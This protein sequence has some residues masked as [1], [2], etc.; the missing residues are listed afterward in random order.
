[1]AEILPHI[2]KQERTVLV[3]NKKQQSILWGKAF[4]QLQTMAAESGLFYQDK[5]LAPDFFGRSSI[6]YEIESE[7]TLHQV[8]AKISTS[9]REFY[10]DECSWVCPGPPMF[11]IHGIALKATEHYIPPLWLWKLQ[12]EPLLLEGKAFDHFIDA[13]VDPSDPD[14]PPVIG[15]VVPPTTKEHSTPLL[16]LKDRAGATAQLFIQQGTQSYNN[17]TLPQDLLSDL[18]GWEKDLLETHYQKLHQR[19]HI[20]YCPTD[21]VGKSLSFLLQCGWDVQDY[22]GKKVRLIEQQPLTMETKEQTVVVKGAIPFT[23][24]SGSSSDI[25]GKIAR[26]ESFF[27]LQDGSVGL[28][29]KSET[30]EQLA[31]CAAMG[32]F[33]GDQLHLPKQRIGAL[34]DLIKEQD[35]LDLKPLLFNA[36]EHFRTQSVTAGKEFTGKLRPYQQ[37]GLAWLHFLYQNQLGG[38]LADD[39]GLGKTVQ[40]LA[41]L[42]LIPKGPHL[43]CLPRSLL[44]NWKKEIQTF[45]PHASLMTHHGPERTKDPAVLAQAFIV[46]TSYGILKKDLPLFTSIQW[47]SAIL[48]EA[49]TIKNSQTEIAKAAYQLPATVKIALSGTPIENHLLELWSLFRFSLPSLLPD[50]KTFSADI[51][52]SYSDARHLSMLKKTIR[53]FILR[54]NK[55][56][57]APDLPRKIEQTIWV[58]MEKEQAETYQDFLQ[59]AKKG[60]MKKVQ[61]DGVKKHRMEILETLLRLRQICCHPLLVQDQESIP[62]AKLHVVLSDLETVY[63]EGRKALVYS[64]FTQ[65][66]SLIKKELIKKKIPF[67]YLDGKTKNREEPVVQFQEDQNIPFFLMSIKAG[68]VGLNLSQADYVFLFDPW[69]NRAAENQAIDRAHRI[70]RKDTVIARRYIMQDTVEEKILAL[71]EK[72]AAL[73]KALIDDQS[74]GEQLTA[75]DLYE[76]VLRC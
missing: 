22:L 71:S 38:I 28:L 18:Q 1:M 16:Q 9:T 66:L 34:A 40:I 4:A 64:Q 60:L 11:F 62:S 39:M 46:L 74:L 23:Q 12:K 36:A 26:K 13:C 61:A 2:D 54:R 41:L 15:G 73:A 72:K 31:Q 6:S 33:I 51:E 7:D 70:G 21:K 3:Q 53:P 42:S 52:A 25:I 58:T 68:G 75:D 55:A 67:V 24:F 76:L 5:R 30:T 37:S 10:L 14:M 47:K 44:F 63:K 32:E 8:R 49:Q 35:L 17:N 65:M 50:E 56:F 69:W 57:A 19:E 20:F 45:L 59:R 29:E 27:S 48:D 43:I